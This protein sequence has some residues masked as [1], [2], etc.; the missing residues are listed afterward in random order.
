MKEVLILLV[1]AAVQGA[2]LWSA[3]A[4]PVGLFVAA[5][6]GWSLALAAVTAVIAVIALERA[7]A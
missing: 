4:T 1:L 6:L 5:C 7:S 2:L 3:G